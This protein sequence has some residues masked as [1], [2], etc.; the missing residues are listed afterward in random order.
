MR[1]LW[2]V[3]ERW[4]SVHGISMG[5]SWG[6]FRLEA[7]VPEIVGR[8]VVDE[9]ACAARLGMLRLR[10]RE[11]DPVIEGGMVGRLGNESGFY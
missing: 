11:G 4:E 5:G 9:D 8:V 2:G 3:D 7:V 6:R 10:P 1:G